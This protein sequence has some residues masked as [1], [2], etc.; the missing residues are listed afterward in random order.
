MTTGL[1]LVKL[2][3]HVASGGRLEGD[4][5]PAT[6][7]AVEA[8]LNAEDPA[9][10]FAPAPGRVELLNL[11]SGPGLRVDRGVESGDVIPPDFDSMIAK[12]IAVGRDR[13]EALA[14]LRRGLRETTALIEDGSTNR[15][16]LLE[17]LEHPDVLAGRVDTTWLDRHRIGAGA[18]RPAHADIAL[19]QAV[20]RA[21]RG[22]GGRRPRALLRLCSPGAPSG[23]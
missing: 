9:M 18:D 16:F 14:R 1:D 2:Q 5:P 10:D 12:V 19:L 15:G 22:R 4:P 13:D 7:H 11:P 17:L 3:L 8:R 21:R 20:T 23:P 6:G